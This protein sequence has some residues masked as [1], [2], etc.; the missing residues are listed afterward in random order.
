MCARTSSLL[1]QNNIPLCKCS[2]FYLSI[3]QRVDI[4][5]CFHFVTIYE[6]PCT[7]FYKDEFSCLLG[8]YLGEK[9]R[10]PLC[11]IFGTCQAVFQR[12]HPILH[13][14]QQRLRPQSLHACVSTCHCLSFRIL[15]KLAGGEWYLLVVLTHISLMANHIEHLFM[16]FLAIF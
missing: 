14:H 5:V 12:R 7:I 8:R 3:L 13:P 11:L 16:Y 4:W 9:M 10:G 1:L 6:H 2:I 15:D